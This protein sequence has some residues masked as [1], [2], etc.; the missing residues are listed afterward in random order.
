MTNGGVKE[1]NVFVSVAGKKHGGGGSGR[2]G[3]GEKEEK[4][5]A[6]CT[7]IRSM[8]HLL[9][10]FCKIFLPISRDNRNFAGR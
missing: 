7:R 8:A 1:K 10:T 5:V 2:E 6:I 3:S 9:S 4:S